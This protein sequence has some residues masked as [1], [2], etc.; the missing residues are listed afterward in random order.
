MTKQELIAHLAEKGGILNGTTRPTLSRQLDYW[1]VDGSKYMATTS[2]HWEPGAKQ[3]G[4]LVKKMYKDDIIR[5]ELLTE[6]T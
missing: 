5:I 4:I 1:D 3:P 2:C 6:I